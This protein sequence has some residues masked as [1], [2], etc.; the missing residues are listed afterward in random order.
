MRHGNIR[1]PRRR[2]MHITTSVLLHS[3]RALVM[4]PPAARSGPALEHAVIAPAV[5]VAPVGMPRGSPDRGHV[6]GAEAAEVDDGGGLAA[7]AA[8]GDAAGAGGDV[9][10]GGEGVGAVAHGDVDGEGANGEEE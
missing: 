8:H 2:Y 3:L 6:A 5:L 10:A 1:S 9:D 7:G 4:P